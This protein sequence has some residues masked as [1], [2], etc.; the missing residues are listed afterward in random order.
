[1]M[2]FGLLSKKYGIMLKSDAACLDFVKLGEILG[3]SI[4][5]AKRGCLYGKIHGKQLE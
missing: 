4:A 2:G 1:M 5:E 3:E